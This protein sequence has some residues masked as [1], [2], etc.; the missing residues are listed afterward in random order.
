MTFYERYE[1]LCRVRGIDR[2]HKA[3]LKSW[4]RPA[5]T[6]RTWKKGHKANVEIVRTQRI[7]TKRLRYLL[8]AP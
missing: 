2:V 4:A 6:S 5:L 7:C 3:L 1:A 8:G